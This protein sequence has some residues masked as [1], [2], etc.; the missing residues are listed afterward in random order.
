[1]LGRWTNISSEVASFILAKGSPPCSTLW[2]LLAEESMGSPGG[3]QELGCRPAPLHR[4]PPWFSVSY[5]VAVKM[6]CFKAAE[7]RT[8]PV[9]AE[10]R[11][12]RR[13]FSVVDEVKTLC[14]SGGW[15]SERSNWKQ[16]SQPYI[17]I[18]KWGLV[19]I[20]PSL[21]F[22]SALTSSS[23]VFKTSI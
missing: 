3:L 14:K 7:E 2:F 4:V 5:F 16:F 17:D 21:V 18:W 19:V 13:F 9:V 10:T 6:F 15:N 11:G 8:S 22:G 12:S 1:M 23:A 20:G